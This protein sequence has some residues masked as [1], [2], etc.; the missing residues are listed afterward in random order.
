ML[1]R[2]D[3]LEHARRTSDGLEVADLAL[4]RSHRTALTPRVPLPGGALSHDVLE[5]RQF[6]GVTHLV[7]ERRVG[8]AM[9]GGARWR[10]PPSRWEQ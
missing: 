6:D 3:D 9:V 7:G 2:E 1:E 4:D 8:V 5:R 10:R